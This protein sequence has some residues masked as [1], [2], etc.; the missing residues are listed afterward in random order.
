[1]VD[2]AAVR[3]LLWNRHR[4]CPDKKDIMKPSGVHP[5]SQ[6][7]GDDP[8]DIHNALLHV[9]T[10]SVH[11]WLAIARSFLVM[12]SCSGPGSLL[13]YATILIRR[14]RNSAQEGSKSHM[15]H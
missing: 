3:V 8:F 15:L 10:S 5:Q 4:G 2:Q 7:K 6:E 12:F 11:G 1:M 9:A 13:S 14:N